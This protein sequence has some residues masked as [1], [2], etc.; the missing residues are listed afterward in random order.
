L[1]DYARLVVYVREDL[2]GGHEY[3][4]YRPRLDTARQIAAL[5]PEARV[6]VVTASQNAA[7]RREV[8]RFA[9]ILKHLDGWSTTIVEDDPS[10]RQ[11][12]AITAIPT[13]IIRSPETGREIGRIVR[14]PISGS[15]EADLLTIA[16][17]NPSRILA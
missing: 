3:D 10:V 5:L 2:G 15:L 12:L 17:Q 11:R 16:E 9:R 8:A 7:C 1:K 4:E 6:K 14:G 13:F